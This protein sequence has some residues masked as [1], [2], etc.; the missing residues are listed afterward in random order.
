MLYFPHEPEDMT[1]SDIR[2]NFA[3]YDDATQPRRLVDGY[4]STHRRTPS[5]APLDAV[6]GLTEITGPRFDATAIAGDVVNLA[7]DPATG[8]RAIGPLMLLSGR[9]LDEEGRPVRRSLVE[10]WQA[11]GAGRYAH[12]ADDNAAPL[13]PNFHGVGR[14][15][16]DDDGRYAFL[17]IK[18]GAY[19]V[20]GPGNWWRPPHIH[21]SLFGSSWMS[22]L[23]TQMYFPGEPLNAQDHI[24]NAIPEASARERV[25][26]RVAENPL[27]PAPALGF[28]FDIV[29]RGRAETP[30]I[31]A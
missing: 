17:T 28:T 22:R 5:A 27:T 9:V 16:T 11:N 29:L 25:L 1:D 26:C 20:P 30:W 21:F 10:L 31:A 2:T 15:L 12:A 13:D 6:P 19:P 8:R 18:P 4:Q 7:V 14:M 24:L 3:P 23:V